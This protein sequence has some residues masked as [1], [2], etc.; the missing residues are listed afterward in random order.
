MCDTFFYEVSLYR[1][2]KNRAE[3]IGGKF[4]KTDSPYKG[5]TCI[6]KRLDKD[7]VIMKTITELKNG[8]N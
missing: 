4:F 1:L 6:C 5:K 3:S 2:T 7:T 8:S